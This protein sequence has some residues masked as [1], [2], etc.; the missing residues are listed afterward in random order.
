[1]KKPIKTSEVYF[2]KL[3]SKG[4][5]EDECLRQRI[6]KVGFREFNHQ[7]CKE[8][9]WEKAMPNSLRRRLT[10][11][12]VT[13]Y[14]RQVRAFYETG[15]D[16]LWITFFRNRMWWCFAKRPVKRLGAG[17]K[18]RRV[19]GGWKNTDIYGNVLSFDRVSGKLLKVRGYQSTICGVEPALALRTINAEISSEVKTTRENLHQLKKTIAKII[20]D[21]HWKDFELLVDLIFTRA[22][23]Q[24]IRELG[25]TEKMLDLE[26]ASPVLGEKA[27]VQV[28]SQSSK[29]EFD[30]YWSQFLKCKD[31]SRCFYVVHTPDKSLKRI[32][33]HKKLRLLFAE[34]IAELAIN[35]GLTE[36]ILKKC[37]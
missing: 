17:D 36:W 22:G 37:P 29:K 13:D 28:K 21:I 34:D 26:V 18:T 31:F 24:R 25:K 20:T 32:P 3:G 10:Q 2:I 19:I 11:G 8:G 7:A 35:S 4:G 14:I 9:R 1:M 12:K 16:A 5:W 15:S 33:K 23:W 30:K 27:M 6:V